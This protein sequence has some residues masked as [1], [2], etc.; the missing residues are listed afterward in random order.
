MVAFCVWRGVLWT[1]QTSNC[2][3]CSVSTSSV[4]GKGAHRLP[5]PQSLTESLWEALLWMLVRADKTGQSSS[6]H[7]PTGRKETN[8]TRKQTNKNEVWYCCDKEP[9]ARLVGKGRGVSA[10]WRDGELLSGMTLSWDLRWSNGWAGCGDMWLEHFR[11]FWS[12]CG[13]GDEN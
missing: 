13:C 6:A 2:S 8:Q 10:L 3:P 12:W 7:A 1:S 11:M 5:S 9:T 4:F